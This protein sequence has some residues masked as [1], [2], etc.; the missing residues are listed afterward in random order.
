MQYKC[1]HIN[2]QTSRFLGSVNDTDDYLL[3]PHF[4][5]N[6]FYLFMLHITG[7]GNNIAFRK[8]SKTF[9]LLQMCTI[10]VYH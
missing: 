4:V 9:L 1:I 3:Q 2:K 6:F 7:F 5:K 8:F 10:T